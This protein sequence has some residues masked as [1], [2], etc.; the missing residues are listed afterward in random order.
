MR[1]SR[2]AATVARG[3]G[4]NSAAACTGARR[5]ARRNHAA[6]GRAD[7]NRMDPMIPREGRK[8]AEWN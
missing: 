3:A 1:F 4:C 6:G 7:R 8:I 5:G 2:A